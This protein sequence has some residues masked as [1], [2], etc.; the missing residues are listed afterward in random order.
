M[1]DSSTHSCKSGRADGWLQLLLGCLLAFGAAIGYA[2]DAAEIS[3]LRIERTDDEMQLS[4]Q[5]NFEL[6]EVVED[7]LLKGIPMVFVM[8]VETLRERWYWYD[9]KVST[10]ERSMRLAY[11]P[12]T[13]RWRLNVA[14]GPGAATPVGLVLNQSYDS[15]A[16]AM[17]VVKR[18]NK[19]KIADAASFDPALRYRAEFQFKLDLTQLPRPFQIGALGQA[20]WE[21]SARAVLPLSVESPK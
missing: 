2:Q 1:M 8:G 11:Q 10:S 15:L 16:Q 14:A 7:A 18:V 13:R 5:V 17:A 19:W 12:L 9:K 3:M 21:I 6:P 20:Q 4:A